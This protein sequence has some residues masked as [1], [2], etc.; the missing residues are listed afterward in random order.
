MRIL[1]DVV[2]LIQRLLWQILSEDE[3]RDD[4]ETQHVRSRSSYW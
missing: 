3:G 1:V 2:V 4:G